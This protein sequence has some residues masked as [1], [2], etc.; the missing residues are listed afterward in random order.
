MEVGNLVG[1]GHES[2]I[3]PPFP[4]HDLSVACRALGDMQTDARMVAVE[5]FQQSVEET[6]CCESVDTNAQ[7]TFLAAR[8]YLG[9]L[10]RM[11][12]DFHGVL[13]LIDET[14]P[15]FGQPN[16]ARIAVEE[17]DAKVFFQCLDPGA[18]ARLAGVERKSGTVETEIFRDCEHL[19]QGDHR[20]M[21]A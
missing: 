21:A 18:D 3:D 7:L 2:D 20:D 16:T 14:A 15:G 12:K 13:D 19:D 9:C 8:L 10:D 17:D 4:Q 5:P 1:L 11:I 6:P